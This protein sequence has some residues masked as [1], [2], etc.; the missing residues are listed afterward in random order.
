MANSNMDLMKPWACHWTNRRDRHIWLCN[1]EVNSLDMMW[2]DVNW[3]W[4]KRWSARA[5]RLDLVTVSWLESLQSPLG[6]SWNWT[7]Q[8]GGAAGHE[9]TAS[10]TEKGQREQC[11]EQKERTREKDRQGWIRLFDVAGTAT[12]DYND[13][14][15]HCNS[16]LTRL[17]GHTSLLYC[18]KYADQINWSIAFIPFSMFVSTV[19]RTSFQWTPWGLYTANRPSSL[20]KRRAAGV[21]IARNVSTTLTIPYLLT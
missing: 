21:V 10:H 5:G 15:H 4:P 9:L 14:R 3:V 1:A 11:E 6:K 2:S 7:I 17:H 16:Y 13:C 19:S 12:D 18:C 20:R 8:R